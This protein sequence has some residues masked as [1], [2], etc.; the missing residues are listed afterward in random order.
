M[1]AETAAINACYGM[2]AMQAPSCYRWPAAGSVTPTLRL[3]D[4]EVAKGL[5]PCDRLKLLRIDEVGVERE[6]LR[7][8]KQLHQAAVLLDDIV[9]Q[10]RDA[11]AGLAGAQNAD[12]VIDDEMRRARALAVAGDI[13]QPARVL[14]EGRH[15]AAEHQQMMPIEVIVRARGAAPLEI[16]RRRISVEMHREQLALDQVR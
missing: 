13:D 6:R 7:I 10:H 9:G 8:A 5:D 2:S 14:Q 3:A 15:I 16:F 4:Q 1:P 12:D 11:E